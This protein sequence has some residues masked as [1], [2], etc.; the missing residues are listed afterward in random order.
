MCLARALPLSAL[1]VTLLSGC[2][3]TQ[4]TL[5]PP[6]PDPSTTQPTLA[7]S[8]TERVSELQAR[9][10]EYAAGAKNLPGRNQVEDR[11]ATG[12]QFALL[13]Q[14]IPLLAGPEMSGDLAQQLRII[15][16][17]RT[18]LVNGSTELAIEPTTDAG[19]RAAQRALAS[20]GTRSFAEV[21]EITKAL[22][23]MRIRTDDLDTASGPLHRLVAAQVIQASAE[24]ISRMSANLGARVGEEKAT[25][26]AVTPAE[27]PQAP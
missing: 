9:A 27:A 3:K 7:A 10:A 23:T 17:T 20:L 19:L 14:I 22:D 15:D 16:G 25:P 24:A 13:S 4:P 6:P 5:A 2:A 12:K 8:I 11:A 26:A 1:F 18:Q 21:T